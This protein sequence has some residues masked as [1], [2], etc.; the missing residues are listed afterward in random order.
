MDL[1]NSWLLLG[2]FIACALL[3]GGALVLLQ[4]AEPAAFTAPA[5]AAKPVKDLHLSGGG[6]EGSN[7]ELRRHLTQA[8]FTHPDA[9]RW[10]TWIKLGG[11]VLGFGIAMLVVPMV[12]V[13]ASMAPEMQLVMQGV[14]ALFGYFAPVIVVD[15]RRA[16]WL[17]RIELALPDALDFMLI[18]VE[19]GQST[20]IAVK[21][22]AEELAP[23]HPELSAGFV[24]LTEALAAGAE[25]QEAWMRLSVDTDNDDLRQLAT[26][27]VQSSTMGTPVA[28]TLRVFSADL[29]DRRVRRIEEKANILP[30][31]MTLG[32]MMFTVPPLLI[33]LLAPALY[34]IASS[35]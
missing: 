7:S 17:K 12:P 22:V 13:L 30:T 8:G 34:R 19:A 14:V 5:K 31:K 28:Q 3:L 11:T 2:C 6:D 26:I 32:T 23:V 33:L 27:I 35:F 1:L 10:L 9:V 29:R 20:D 21:R 18:C 4:R 24:A 15:K 25:R 16:A